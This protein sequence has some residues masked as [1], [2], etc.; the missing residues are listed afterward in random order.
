MNL[1]E[2]DGRRTAAAL[3]GSAVI[4]LAALG[5]IF[6]LFTAGFNAPAAGPGQAAVAPGV[7]DTTIPDVPTTSTTSVV[8]PSP[9]GV[10]FTPAT[11]SV[12]P[13]ELPT[14]TATAPGPSADPTPAAPVPTPGPPVVQP[15]SATSPPGIS[16]V[17]M[18]CR[19]NGDRVQ[20][21]L[22][23]RTTTA[24][25]VMLIA[26]GKVEQQAAVGPGVVSV[27]ATG[28]RGSYCMAMIGT[29]RVGPVT[30]S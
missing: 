26:G 6:W 1:D 29:Q 10:P 17:S 11:V 5:A 24:V 22:S 14:M 15:P 13:P 3:L 8:V 28:K 30:A 4:G 18:S 7:T 21:G 23:F 12:A 2:H 20:G 25:S 19:K 27:T 16:E 9:T